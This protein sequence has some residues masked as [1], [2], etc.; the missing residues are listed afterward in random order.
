MM[1][2]CAKVSLGRTPTGNRLLLFLFHNRLRYLDGFWLGHGLGFWLGSRLHH[3]KRSLEVGAAIGAETD[4]TG[5]LLA[6]TVTELGIILLD[7]TG[8]GGVAVRGIRVIAHDEHAVLIGAHGKALRTHDLAVVY[9]QL[10]LR[11]SHPFT[12]L[13]AL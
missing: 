2:H 11:Y 1:G 5:Q 10:L 13:W 4:A 6:T 12:A 7:R 3:V 8:I 9:H